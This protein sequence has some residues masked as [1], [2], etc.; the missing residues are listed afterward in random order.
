[1]FLQE[2]TASKHLSYSNYKKLCRNKNGKPRLALRL[3]V[4]WLDSRYQRFIERVCVPVALFT[5]IREGSVLILAGTP[6]ILLEV[7]QSI[8]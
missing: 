6:A 1:M 8:P 7:Y 3:S 2:Q 4:T 5:F